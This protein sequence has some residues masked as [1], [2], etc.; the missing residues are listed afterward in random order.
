M[1]G[2]KR[3]ERT[4]A[5]EGI[6]EKGMQDVTEVVWSEKKQH[7]REEDQGREVYGA[8]SMQ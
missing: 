8:N 4:E 7:Q 5:R 6:E 3:K 1:R 2:D